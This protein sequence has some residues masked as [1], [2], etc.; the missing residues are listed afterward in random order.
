MSGR[1]DYILGT[2]HDFSMVGIREPRTHNDHWM[3][4]GVL[5]RDGAIRNSA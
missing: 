2:R 1:G 3:V 5:H 4:L